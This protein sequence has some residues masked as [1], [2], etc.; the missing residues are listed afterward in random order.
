MCFVLFLVL[1]VVG[2]EVIQCFDAWFKG[3]SSLFCLGKLVIYGSCLKR[4]QTK[5]RGGPRIYMSN[6]RVGTNLLEKDLS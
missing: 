4:T 5:V 3:V 6:L 2:E 1:C